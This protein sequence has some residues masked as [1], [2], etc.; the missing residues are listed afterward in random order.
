MKISGIYKI[1]NKVNGK[2]YVGSTNDIHTRWNVHTCKLNK[3]MH[4]SQ[5][6][7]RAWDKY[8]QDNFDFILIER[9]NEENLL[10]IEQNYLIECSKNKKSNYN[11][12]YNALSPFKGRKHTEQT[13]RKM[14]NRHSGK[15]NPFYGKCHN[16]KIRE[17][18]RTNS[19]IGLLSKQKNIQSYANTKYHWYNKITNQVEF[20]TQYDLYTKYNLDKGN[21]G[22]VVK[23]KIPSCKGWC[24]NS[25]YCIDLTL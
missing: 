5:K 10:N 13:K 20:C 22:H 1:I 16:K 9:V 2:Y 17:K 24:I 15:F 3:N 21:V 4:H 18:I 11:V 6:L 12:N 14:S 25:Y 23:K 7:Q 8:K 19:I